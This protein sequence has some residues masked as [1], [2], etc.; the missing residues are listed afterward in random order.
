MN[1]NR[2]FAF[3]KNNGSSL[4]TLSFNNQFKILFN[5]AKFLNSLNQLKLK[6]THSKKQKNV[7]VNHC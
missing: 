4:V 7:H 1:W 6:V 3:K 2:S 5:Q